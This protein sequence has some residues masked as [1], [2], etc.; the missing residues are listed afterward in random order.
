MLFALLNVE[1]TPFN[2][3]GLQAKSANWPNVQKSF[4]NCYTFNEISPFAGEIFK[5]IIPNKILF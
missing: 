1:P 5:A 4:I 3:K 2:F